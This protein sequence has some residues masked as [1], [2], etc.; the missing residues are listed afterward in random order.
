MGTI[1]QFPEASRLSRDSRS[2]T[3]SDDA[4][5]IILP[6]IRIERHPEQPDGG[7]TTTDSRPG[8][9]RRGHR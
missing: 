5:V 1:I 4:T 6:S 9:R 3:P 8:R 2:V 7:P